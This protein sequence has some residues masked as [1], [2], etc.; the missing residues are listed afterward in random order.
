MESRPSARFDRRSEMRRYLGRTSPPKSGTAFHENALP[1][2]AY[3][4]ISSKRTSLVPPANTAWKRI[5]GRFVLWE[6]HRV[7]EP[8]EAL[9]GCPTSENSIL[10][11]TSVNR[12]LDAPRLMRW[13]YE[14]A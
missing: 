3:P 13:H 12:P 2:G 7:T 6:L 4:V 10:P 9:C 11:S 8:P 5:S 1:R 14:S